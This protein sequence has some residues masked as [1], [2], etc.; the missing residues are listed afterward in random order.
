MFHLPA[1]SARLTGVGPVVVVLAVEEAMALEVSSAAFSFLAHPA[2]TTA[3][4]QIA[5]RVVRCSVSIYPPSGYRRVS[6]CIV[7][8]QTN[9]RRWGIGGKSQDR[10][11]GN[12]SMY[13]D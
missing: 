13:C 9:V 6:P 12:H 5:V 8:S 3:Q 2:R 7:L 1:T 4:Q 10:L 11:L